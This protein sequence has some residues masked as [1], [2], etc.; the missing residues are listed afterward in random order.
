MN[1]LAANGT[2]PDI[3]IYVRH[4]AGCKHRD[5]EFYRRCDC[6][7]HLR[8]S[9]GGEQFRQAAE[10]R[11][12]QEAEVYKRNLED[13]LSGRAVAPQQAVTNLI[14]DC[15]KIFLQDKE[16]QGVKPGTL[17]RYR[18]E[19]ARLRE[20]CESKEGVFTVQGI[21]RELLTR[22][23]ATWPDLYPSGNT[24]Q[25][26][27][28]RY[29]SFL[30][31]GYEA[32]WYERIPRLPKM[33]A[34][35]RP[36][37][38]LSSEQY[39][40]LLA[41]IPQAKPKRWGRKF[42]ESMTPEMQQR[43]HALVRLQRFS[44]LAIGDA[45]TLPR[46]ELVHDPVRRIYR[47]ITDRQKTGTH[48]SVPIPLDVA[49]ELIALKG[50]HDDYFFWTGEGTPQ[51]ISKTWANRYIRPLFEAAGLAGDGHMLSHRLRDTFAVDLLEKGVPMEEVSKLLGHKSI[52]T[53][54][55]YY[56]KWMKGRQDRLDNLVIGTWAA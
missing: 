51:T 47:V 23:A 1:G 25:K 18:C 32:Q 36:T 35:E 17:S 41:A 3:T 19:L 24:R 40:Q 56:A 29:S 9:R 38:P 54:E 44:G 16:V 12:W 26:V 37:L 50:P 28:E 53:T 45:L 42:S 48:V 31:Y 15:V 30:R 20:F 27:R 39:S 52:K 5:N 13:Q 33:S 4:S 14:Q 7:K 34:D 11:S 49:E 43:I 2:T 21:T 8:W 22:F 55:R 6:R 46:A 10:T